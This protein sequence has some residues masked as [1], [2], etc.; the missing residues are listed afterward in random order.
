MSELLSFGVL[1]LLTIGVVEVA[2]RALKLPKTIIPAVALV[3]GLVLTIVGNIADITSLTFLAGIAV[4][5]SSVGLFDQ[6]KLLGL[7]K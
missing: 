2:K 1:V 5:L 6:K 3:V 7:L 4:G